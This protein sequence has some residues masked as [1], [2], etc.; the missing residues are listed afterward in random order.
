MLNSLVSATKRP[1]SGS[2]QGNS[3]DL[4]NDLTAIIYR[5]CAR[6]YGPRR[7][8]CATVRMTQE[9]QHGDDHLG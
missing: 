4:L 1:G 3:E 7:A 5:L 9:L 6:L 8:K 2:V